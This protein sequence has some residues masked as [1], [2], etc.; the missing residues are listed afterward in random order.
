MSDNE[1]ELKEPSRLLSRPKNNIAR[2]RMT[3]I[4]A[5]GSMVDLVARRRPRSDGYQREQAAQG[6]EN[7]AAPSKVDGGR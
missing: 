2:P 6:D 7:T 5:M 4:A 3:R 1:I